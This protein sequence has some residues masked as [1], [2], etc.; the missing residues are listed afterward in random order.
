MVHTE[1]DCGAVGAAEV[2]EGEQGVGDALLFGGLL[3]VGVFEVPEGAGGV[4][5]VAGID[6]H[7]IAGGGGAVGGFGVE[8]DVGHEWDVASES[9]GGLFYQRHVGGLSFTLGGEAYYLT[10][11]IGYL[12]DL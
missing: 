6:S 4:D 1:A 5:E 3:L 10:S 7:F 2:E 8:M 11:G 12:L 9:G